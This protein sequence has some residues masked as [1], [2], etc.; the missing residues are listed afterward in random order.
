M[1]CQSFLTQVVSLKPGDLEI[2]YSKDLGDHQGFAAAILF[3]YQGC[4]KSCFLKH[5][6]SNRRN[7]FAHRISSVVCLGCPVLCTVVCTI[8]AI[9][10]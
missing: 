1:H 4:V 2:A 9:V 5:N 10:L 3:I 6:K 7:I 8:S